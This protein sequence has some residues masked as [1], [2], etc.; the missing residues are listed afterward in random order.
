MFSTLDLREHSGR[1]GGGGGRE[2]WSQEHCIQ[3]VPTHAAAQGE[4][5]GQVGPVEGTG[6]GK[7]GVFPSLLPALGW[8]SVARPSSAPCPA[9]LQVRQAVMDPR[10]NQSTVG[11]ISFSSENQLI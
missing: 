11:N 2:W 8:P 9:K 4:V 5:R 7:G 1:P 10:G 6:A 3:Q